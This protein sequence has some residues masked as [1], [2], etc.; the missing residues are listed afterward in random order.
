MRPLGMHHPDDPTAWAS[1]GQFL[2]GKDILVAP[3][4]EPNA[5]QRQVYLPTGKKWIDPRN[6]NTHSG[7]STITVDVTLDMIPIFVRSD[8]PTTA[9]ILIKAMTLGV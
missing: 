8:A 5:T 4:V 6:N 2:F 7:G 9:E 3:I 1:E